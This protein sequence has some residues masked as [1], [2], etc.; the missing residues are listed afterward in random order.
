MAT[1]VNLPKV[2]SEELPSNPFAFEVFALV[3]KQKS[4]AK[5]VELL[6]KYEHPSLK[7]L[8]ICKN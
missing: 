7:S 2:V 1:A 5:K 4:N 3:S 8:F 6:K